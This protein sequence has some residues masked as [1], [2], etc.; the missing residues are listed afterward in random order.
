MG[1][2]RNGKKSLVVF[3]MD[4]VLVDV[5]ASYREV[6]RLSVIFYLRDVIGVHIPNNTFLTLSD[7]ASIKK[8]GG[9]N[10]DWDLTYAI[11]NGYLNQALQN[12]DPCTIKK[13]SNLGE[14][15]DDAR[16]LEAF[17]RIMRS[18]DLSA[19]QKLLIQGNVRELHIKTGGQEGGAS[20]F[21]LNH[22][23]V[24]SGN[25]IKRIF[26]EIYLGKLLFEKIYGSRPIFFHENGYIERESLIPTLDQ[27]ERLSHTFTLS[28]ATGRPAVE[29]QNALKQFKIIDLFNTVVSEDDIVAAE[30][31][32][33]E[34]LR[35]PHPFSLKLCIDQ[36]GYS[37]DSRIHYIGDMPDDMAAASGAGMIP[38]GFVN[39]NKE[40]SIREHEE[41]IR[42][43][44]EHGAQ[45]VFGEFQQIVDYLVRFGLF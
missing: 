13:L 7:I 26:Q 18:C 10:N 3:D 12:I 5:T 16:M 20:P 42:L 43:L 30:R 36:S 8:S 38:I 40:E 2:N 22:R 19:L 15:E 9:L 35:K 11:I 31:K 1:Y 41:H 34:T 39:M 4:G 44:W 23:D 6:T 45:E 27:L 28:I 29:A 17:Q 25:I 33:A 37:H 32:A 21:L 24:L 14:I